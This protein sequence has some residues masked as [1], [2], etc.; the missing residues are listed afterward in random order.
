MVLEGGLLKVPESHPTAF[1]KEPWAFS[2]HPQ[3]H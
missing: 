1:P 2:D 3:N